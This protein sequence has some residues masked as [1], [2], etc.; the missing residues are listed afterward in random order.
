MHQLTEYLLYFG[1]FLDRSLYT[2]ESTWAAGRIQ[3]WVWRCYST[4][5]ANLVFPSLYI[6]GNSSCWFP[7][8]TF[9]TTISN[10]SHLVSYPPHKH[11]Q[12]TLNKPHMY[13]H[14]R[15][16]LHQGHSVVLPPPPLFEDSLWKKGCF[17]DMNK[18]RIP[19]SLL[20][21]GYPSWGVVLFLFPDN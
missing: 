6:V 8:T 13:L 12:S 1:V 2:F 19:F 4:Y 14:N 21:F 7:T 18:N 10:S 3:L 20:N 17:V 16:H 11:I 15:Q 9:N 5:Y